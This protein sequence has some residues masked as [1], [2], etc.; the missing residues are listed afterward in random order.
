FI[1]WYLFYHNY[2]ILYY[3]SITASTFLSSASSFVNN[4]TNTV[5]TR[6][7]VIT[8]KYHGNAPGHFIP[9][10]DAIFNTNATIDPAITPFS[11]ALFHNKPRINTGKVADIRVPHPKVPNIATA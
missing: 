6:A 1:V 2:F 11:F 10:K 9:A 5:T 3:N 4:E 7:I 8:L